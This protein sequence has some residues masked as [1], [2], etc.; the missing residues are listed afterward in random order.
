[1]LAGLDKMT[2]G[3]CKRRDRETSSPLFR[4]VHGTGSHQLTER[5]RGLTT[6]VATAL[7]LFGDAASASYGDR[8]TKIVVF[9]SRAPATAVLSWPVLAEIGHSPF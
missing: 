4:L 5:D 9:G 8:L 3:I 2:N 6:A 7:A 1:L